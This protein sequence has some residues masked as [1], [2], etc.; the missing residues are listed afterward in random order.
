MAILASIGPTR[1]PFG[2]LSR[3]AVDVKPHYQS[4]PDARKWRLRA[5][6]AV[7]FVAFLWTGARWRG[8]LMPSRSRSPIL[9]V[10]EGDLDFG[11]AWVTDRF[12]WT[13]RLVNRS[14]E[15]VTVDRLS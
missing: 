7:A 13:V 3:E 1:A 14:R 15:E 9:V 12:D 8:S 5:A 2:D 4:T 10:K 6:F 11:T